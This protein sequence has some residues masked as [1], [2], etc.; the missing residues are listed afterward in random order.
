MRALLCFFF[1]LLIGTRAS[2][3]VLISILFGE[4]LNTGQLE[5]GLVISPSFCS[6][7]NTGSSYKSALGLGIYFNWKL[8]DRWYFHPEGTA[9]GAF[10]GKKITPYPT[11]DKVID[12]LYAGGNISR[13]FTALSLPLLIR[14][15]IA[16]LFFAEAGPQAD[17]M[18]SKKDV[19]M[20]KA[21]GNDI[22]YTRNVKDDYTLLDLAWATGLEYRFKEKASMAVSVRYLYGL[23]NIAKTGP[24]NQHN[25]VWSI[26]V[27]IPIGAGKSTKNEKHP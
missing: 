1:C 22:T 16:G 9:K 3:Q 20:A 23:T 13:N 14:Y 8:S 19:F 24:G 17:L 11:G 15:R 10:G 2:S 6:V 4:K 5:F 7:T 25:S 12:S 26:N 21:D 18:I 27:F